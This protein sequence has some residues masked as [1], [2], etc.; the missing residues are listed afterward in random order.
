M[1][2]KKKKFNSIY[3]INNFYINIFSTYFTFSLFSSFS[4]PHTFTPHT[5]LS[6][7]FSFNYFPHHIL[8]P[9]LLLSFFSDSLDSLPYLIF[10]SFSYFM[11]HLL[12]FVFLIPY[13]IFP[14]FFFLHVSELSI[15]WALVAS[16]GRFVENLYLLALCCCKMFYTKYF[17][18]L[19]MFVSLGSKDLGFMYLEF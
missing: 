3:F 14:S 12:S 16:Q 6:P 15:A 17:Q 7:S 9:S 8:S 19:T 2:I 10:P 1:Y 4:P 5:S 18:H 11:S 13:L